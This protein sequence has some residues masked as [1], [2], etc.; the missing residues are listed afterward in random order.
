MAAQTATTSDDY[1]NDVDQTS[2]T[3]YDWDSDL[4][5][6]LQLAGS[7][8]TSSIM[9]LGG[10]TEIMQLLEPLAGG[11]VGSGDITNIK[12]TVRAAAE[13]F[14]EEGTLYVKFED[15]SNT[16]SDTIPD[17]DTFSNYEFDGDLTYWGLSQSEARD[18]V[19][20]GGPF[21]GAFHLWVT[22][23][24]DRCIPRIKWVK[25]QITYELPVSG[26]IHLGTAF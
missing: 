20:G 18:F 22:S 3:D 24:V 12:I 10:S 19:D 9:A 2:T 5:N 23:D 7:T 1:F 14:Q 6:V 16:K 17:D 15:G 13:L 26:G 4:T 8:E 25:A 11:E 21:S